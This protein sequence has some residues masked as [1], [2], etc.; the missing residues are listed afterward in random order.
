VLR[1]GAQ[2]RV[3]PEKRSVVVVCVGDPRGVARVRGLGPRW[4]VGPQTVHGVARVRGLGPRWCGV[5]G[6][7]PQWC[8]GPQVRGLGPNES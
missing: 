1:V 8:A 2:V 7:G 3:V 4:C 6:V 5:H